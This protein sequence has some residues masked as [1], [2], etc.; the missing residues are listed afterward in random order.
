M[1]VDEASMLDLQMF[2]ALLTALRPGCQ[3]IL[4][5]DPNQLPPVGPGHVLAS[6]LNV[7][8]RGRAA[9]PA[10]AVAT[11]ASSASAAAASAT[12]GVWGLLPRVHLGEVFRQSGSGSIVQSALQIMRGA[13]HEA[14]RRGWRRGWRGNGGQKVSLGG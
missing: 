14:S 1:L 11:A 9:A 10:A 7:K 2:A 8:A 13:S 3:L 5:G 12:D 6:L 4:V